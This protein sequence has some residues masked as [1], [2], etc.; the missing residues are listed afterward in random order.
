MQAAVLSRKHGMRHA[1]MRAAM[2]HLTKDAS[3]DTTH[4]T[5]HVCH[6]HPISYMSPADTTHTRRH[7]C[8]P[9]PI[10]YYTAY[11]LDVMYATRI[12]FVAYYR[13]HTTRHVCHPHPISRAPSSRRF[14]VPTK[15]G[16]S[17]AY[18]QKP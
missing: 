9:H 6:P 14:E 11:I 3:Q 7:V 8:H 13:W 18:E 5:R 1:Y 17:M 12:P 15:G 10:T 16:V 4:T 2:L